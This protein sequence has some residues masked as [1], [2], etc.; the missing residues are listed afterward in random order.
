MELVAEN[1]GLERGGRMLVSGLSFRLAPGSLTRLTGANG[2]GK[3]SL[4][5]LIAGLAEPAQGA[6]RLVGGDEELGIGAQAHFVAHQ[7]AVKPA[8]SMRENL[9]FWRDFLGGDGM[10]AALDAFGLRPLAELP[11]AWAS[12]GQKRRLGLARLALAHRPLWLLDEPTVGL[13]AASEAS[14]THLMRAHLEKGG[15]ILAATHV[16]LQ[17]DSAELRIGGVA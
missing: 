1:L 3:T 11:A 6:V 17:M 4:L 7:E 16:P 10:D 8:L 2:A 14:L 12:A 9:E 13:D 15:I 5:R